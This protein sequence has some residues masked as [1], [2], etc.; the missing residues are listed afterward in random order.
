MSGLDHQV[1]R[2]HSRGRAG[3]SA[4]DQVIRKAGES[5]LPRLKEL[6][7]IFTEDKARALADEMKEFAMKDNI[8]ELLI[9]STYLTESVSAYDLKGIDEITRHM[10]R[11]IA[12]IEGKGENS[13]GH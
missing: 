7:S 6:N 10:E 12:D 3:S 5:F 13:D 2:M 9:L 1:F 4:S 8:P 11:M